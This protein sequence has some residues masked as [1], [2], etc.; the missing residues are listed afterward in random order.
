MI[1]K[2][3]STMAIDLLFQD[4][5]NIPLSKK[6]QKICTTILPLGRYAYK[7]LPMGVAC[8]PDIFQTIMMDFLS[9]LNNILIYIDDILLLQY[10]GKTEVDHQNKMEAMQVIHHKTRDR[11]P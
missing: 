9:D 10:H 3:K 11:I 7:W 5:Y 2:F 6:S 4:Y 1:E 8:V